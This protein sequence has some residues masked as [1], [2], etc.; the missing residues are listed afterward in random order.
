IGGL[1][2]AQGAATPESSKGGNPGQVL[3]EAFQ[4]AP[5]V[6][7]AAKTEQ[8]N[9]ENERT[10]EPLSHLLVARYAMRHCT[11]RDFTKILTFLLDH[12]GGFSEDFGKLYDSQQGCDLNIIVLVAEKTMEPLSLCAHRLILHTN[13]EAHV[14]LPESG[15]SST[16]QVEEECLYFYSRQI[17]ISMNSVKCFHKLAVAYGIASLQA[18]CNQIFLS[19]FPLDPSF[20]VHLELYDY[21]LTSGDAQ[22]QEVILQ[23][24]AW[25]FEALTR[26][27]AWLALS[28]EKMK[29]LLSRTDVVIESE[30]SLLKAL[31]HWARSNV[32][33]RGLWEKIRFPMLLPEQ[34][35]EL[36]FT[37]A[38][39]KDG[40]N[41]YQRNIMDALDF[42]TVP[43]KFLRQ[44]KLHDLSSDSYVPRFY[45]GSAWSRHLVY[46]P[47]LQWFISD[48]LDGSNL[49]PPFET[50]KHPSFLFKTQNISW[51][52]SYQV[53]PTNSQT[54]SS[55]SSDIS[56]VLHHALPDS[57]DDAIQYENKALLLCQNFVIDVVNIQNGTAVVPS[58]ASSACP[59]GYSSFVAVVRPVYK[60]NT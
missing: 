20:H 14:L 15:N 6:R 50:S 60:L 10:Q 51:S 45:T 4:K 37:L 2:L 24:L 32:T 39:H 9:N 44:Y 25:N 7:E 42:H 5:A 8:D 11:M 28:S 38:L 53:L 55:S 21:S 18:Y 13:H 29:A 3:Q 12:S 46:N 49:F 30:W 56:L 19:I 57:S 16:L 41:K 58:V 17:E 22:L 27:E 48:H 36:R 35:L 59:N 47:S 43:L 40:E 23:Y 1:L 54:D 26:T 33:T 31:Y 34:L 52:F